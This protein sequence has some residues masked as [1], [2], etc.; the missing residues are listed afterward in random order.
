[1]FGHELHRYSIADGIR[2]GNVLGFDPCKVLTFKDQDLRKAVALEKAKADTVEQALADPKKSK[3]LNH[4]MH[5]PMAGGLDD[6]GA[7]IKGV[8]DYIPNSQYQTQRYQSVVVQDIVDNWVT[9]SLNGKF[10]A[11]FATT[12]IPEAIEYYRLLKKTAPALKITALFDPSIDNMGGAAMKEDGLAEIIGDYN[13]RYEQDFTISTFAKMKKDIAARLAHKRPYERVERTPEKQIDLLIVVDQM[14]TGFDSKWINT[15]YLDKMLQDENV[16]QAFSRTNRLFGHD[17]QFG[18]IKYY[19]RPHTMEKQIEAAVKLYSGDKAL[20][21]FADKL[22]QNLK[23]MNSIFS[24]MKAVFQQ[25]GIKDVQKIPDEVPERKKFANLFKQFND[26]LDAAKVQGFVWDH[27]TYTFTEEGTGETEEIKVAIH[28]KAYKVLALRYK[29]LFESMTDGKTED[30][31]YDIE[32]YLT[33]IDTDAIDA[34]YM[35]CRFDQYLKL[36]HHQGASAKAIQRAEEELHKAFATLSQ[37]EQKFANMFL[38]DIQRG[39]VEPQPGKTLRDYITEYMS[40]A[41][42]DQIHRVAVFLGLEEEKLRSMMERNVTDA[43]INEFGHFSALKAT[44][45]KQK[46]QA[47]FERIEGNKKIN[48]PKVN[49]KI[50]NLL[51]DFIMSGGFDID[52][53]DGDEERQRNDVRNSEDA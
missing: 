8:E 11:I 35:N 17:K 14:L 47:Y 49:M 36:L 43:N 30:L 48:L 10:H 4:Y 1:M 44:V 2:D 15:L 22:N 37:E 23:N 24:D 19:R 20:G 34:D 31:P 6:T 45:D 16:I 7:Y 28:E 46:A 21:L 33:A 42:D 12:S 40:K 29:E 13:R 26:Y 50:D 9:L 52:M 3:I 41:K 38:H 18:V 27:L 51:R 5:L 53:P 25:A 32:G 39:D